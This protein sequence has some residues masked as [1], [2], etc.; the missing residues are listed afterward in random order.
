MGLFFVSLRTQKSTTLKKTN[1]L[2]AYRA[3]NIIE[4]FQTKYTV[5]NSLLKITVHGE[6]PE[7]AQNKIHHGY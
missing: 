7:P 4:H 1:I 3:I 5:V 6:V 2:I